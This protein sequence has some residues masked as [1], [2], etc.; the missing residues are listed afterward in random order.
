MD[1]ISKQNAEIINPGDIDDLITLEE[2]RIRRLFLQRIDEIK[3]S[4]TQQK[5]EELVEQGR[6]QDVFAIIEASITGLVVNIIQRI[7]ASA[8]FTAD[9]LREYVAN[10]STDMREQ[11][12]GTEEEQE[13]VFDPFSDEFIIEAKVK[14]N[15]FITSFMEEQERAIRRSI[16]FAIERGEDNTGIA[17]AIIAAIGLTTL[18]VEAVNNFRLALE[19]NPTEG[20]RR[21]LRDRRFDSTLENVEVLT[22]AQIERMVQRY[23]ELSLQDRADVIGET[24]AV[25]AVNAGIVALFFQQA[26]IGGLI[27]SQFA[28][29]WRTRRDNRVRLS[30]VLMNGQRQ[31]LGRTFISGL[32]N[33]LRYPGDSRAPVQDIVRCRCIIVPV[34]MVL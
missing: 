30:H 5:I 14:Q 7:I 22:N 27:G 32:G 13:I 24:E 23:Q 19:R 2:R 29:E 17:L 8:N 12:I 3:T 34:L 25:G 18:R 20:L 28:F 16:S 31:L 10:L 4:L 1:A 33:R 15:S 26:L 9:N 11:V 21:E 6:I